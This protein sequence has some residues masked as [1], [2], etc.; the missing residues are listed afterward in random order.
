MNDIR[1]PSPHAVYSCLDGMRGVAALLI[2]LRHTQE[3][4]GGLNFHQ[5]YLAVDLFFA[6]SG[7]VI[8]NAYERQLLGRMTARTFLSLRI[9]RL[10]PLYGLGIVFALL[11]SLTDGASWISMAW[12]GV[13]SLL[14]LPNPNRDLIIAFP[15]NIPTWSLFFE[16]VV[17]GIY[18]VLLGVL[19]GYRLILAMAAALAVVAYY[20][21]FKS[22]MSL[23]FGWSVK[24]LPY[25]LFRVFFSFYVGVLI[26][27][28]RDRLTVAVPGTARS[29]LLA[30]VLVAALALILMANPPES[31][32]A[33][34]DLLAITVAFPILVCLGISVQPSGT[35]RA[36]FHFAGAVSYAIYIL[37]EPLGK[38]YAKLYMLLSA[39]PV[40]AATPW[41]GLTFLPLLILGADLLDRFYDNPARAF[42]KRIL[43]RPMPVEA[44]GHGPSPAPAVLPPT[45]DGTGM[46]RPN[47]E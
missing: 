20:T 41:L 10:Y 21:L 46:P 44:L 24:S 22:D 43:L 8:A 19:V 42:A 33:I 38:L 11:V 32:V 30:W 47:A 36:L 34:Y 5:S 9:A 13:L 35:T 6:L 39:S 12:H 1:N 4:F 3:L 17:N 27:R 18:V 40:A 23:D 29:N 45:G 37:H 26:Y 2:V 25:G 15:I 16:V 28:M 7:F 14:F 31:A